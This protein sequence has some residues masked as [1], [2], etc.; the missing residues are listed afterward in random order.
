MPHTVLITFHRFPFEIAQ[1]PYEVDT[2]IAHLT[3]RLQTSSDSSRVTQLV[4]GDAPLHC[5]LLEGRGS[6]Y[7]SL[8]PPQHV[9]GP[10][11]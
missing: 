8:T 6:A 7:F 5:K 1:Q 2:I 4:C 10:Q 11:S 3:K 9:V